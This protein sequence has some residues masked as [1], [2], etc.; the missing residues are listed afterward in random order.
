MAPVLSAML[1]KAPGRGCVEDGGAGRQQQGWRQEQVSHRIVG[2]DELE[3]ASPLGL[4]EDMTHSFT[5]PL[6]YSH[7][8]SQW[9]TLVPVAGLLFYK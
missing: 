4:Q 9:G 5:H 2:W 8:H 1:T 6:T 3:G 7:T